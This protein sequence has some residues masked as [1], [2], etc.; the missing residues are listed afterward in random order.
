MSA[1]IKGSAITFA[2]YVYQSLQGVDL[3]CDWL[4]A[5]TCYVRVRFECDDE[6]VVP[7]GLDDVV[8]ERQDGL[9]DV[10]Q[11]KFTPSPE[12]YALDWDWLTSKPG[13][14]G[15]TSRSLL[16]KW[17]DA[18]A[19]IDPAKLGEVSLITNRVPDLS[20][21]TCL[22]GGAFIDYKKASADDQVNVEAELGGEAN[23][24]RFFKL[25]QVR[26]SNKGYLSLD[27][28]VTD[29]LRKHSTAEGIETL[30]NR[31]VQ[32]AVQKKHPAPEGWIT[33]DILRATLR[34]V[35]P[36]P[37]PEDFVIPAGY[38]VPDSECHARFV[39]AVRSVPAQPLVLTG[40]PG[41]G[42]S[43]YLSQLCETLSKRD[44]PYVRHH[45]YLSA[46]D[47]TLDRYTSH[48]VEASL[49]SQIKR[50]H[51]DVSAPDRE[52][53][54][55][56]AACAAYY[57]A[58]GKPFVV[59]IDG[60]DHVW[61]SQGH[62][63][64]PLDQLFEQLLPSA[65]NLV[66]VVGTQPVDDAQLPTRLLVAAPRAS[67]HELP[68]MSADAVLHYLRRQVRQGRLALRVGTPHDESEL[69]EAA[70]ELRSR[71]GG[72]PLHVIYATEELVRTGQ[73][74]SK[75]SVE[76]LSGDLSHGVAAYYASLWHLLSASQRDVLRLI[77]GFTFFWPKTAF[78]QLATLAGTA[79]PEV[80]A[81][82]H[83]LHA[84][85]AGLKPFHESLVV[86]V[87]QTDGFS[88][89]LNELIGYVETWLE[90]AAPQALCVN[91]LWA[92]KARRGHPDNL[93]AGLQR[94]WVLA[95]LQEGYPTTLMESLLANAEEHGVR[96]VRYADAYRLRH[97]KH[98]LL[99]SLSYR[100]MG[101]DAARLQ[102]C[103]WTLTLEDGVIDEA[104]ASRHERAVVDVAALGLALQA[105]GRSSEAEICGRDA[106]RRVRGESR[107]SVRNDGRAKNLYLAKSLTTLGTLDA[108]AAKTARW[109]D[110][111]R[112][113]MGR[114][115]LE[116]Y[117]DRDELRRTVD[118]A[119]ALSRPEIKALACDSS[120]RIAAKAG[121]DL[122]AWAEFSSLS[123]GVLIGCLGALAGKKGATLWIRPLDLKW[124]EGSYEDRRDALSDL[125]HDWFFGAAYAKLTAEGAATQTN[126]PVFLHQEKVSENLDHLGL[127]GWRVAK[128]WLTGTPVKFSHI[129]EAFHNSRPFT[130]YSNFDHSQGA[131]DFRRTLHGIAVDVQLLSTRFGAAADV[132]AADLHHAMDQTWFDA[133]EFR[134][135]YVSSLSK[136]LS[137]EAAE[138]FVRQQ[139]ATF[140]ATVEEETGIRMM[141]M[142]EL[143]EM[144]LRHDL[145]DL[146]AELCRQT[147]ELALGY[148]QRKDPAL[149]DVM[150]ALEYLVPAAPDDARRLL[151][152]IAPQV[153]NVLAFTDGKGT[154]HVPHQADRLL[155]MLNREALVAK[156]REHTEA[157]EWYHAENSLE[158]YVT[159]VPG[160]STMVRAILRTGLHAGA[161]DALKEV[162]D[163]GTSLA[164]ELL[165][166]AVRHNGADIGRISE[167]RGGSTKTE[168]K[169]FPSDVKSYGVDEIDRLIEDLR[170]HYGIR[171]DILREWF[172]HWVGQGQGS[173]LIQELEPRLLSDAVRGHDLSE[174]LEPA[175]DVKLKLAGRPAAFPYIVQAQIF[176]GGWLGPMMEETEESQARLRLVVRHYKRRCDEFFAKSSVSWLDLPRRK[177]VVPSDIM[178]F[179][180]V[181]QGRTAEAV[182]FAEAMVQGVQDDTRTLRLSAPMWAGKLAVEPTQP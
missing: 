178:V 129:Y 118:I 136:V 132:D 97:L 93:V 4:D 173:R 115:L 181:L 124:H 96:L 79:L 33:L 94:D 37:L 163:G 131:R 74:L 14:V 172:A 68:A 3:L 85:P 171:G 77:C 41:R 155:A 98:R 139:K 111:R 66:I 20:M 62:D 107:F 75:W 169:P 101:E 57:K 28:H 39:E 143:C 102:A 89:R 46:T 55:A 69:Q 157:G 25:L 18:L 99:N 1:D 58:R 126:A 19:G 142:L 90:T 52:L 125:A 121:A 105:R 60:L 86:F 2:G 147:W 7:Q 65:D 165:G 61:R 51:S 8:A 164:T 103:T 43:T 50:F 12:K 179:F 80:A 137:D 72:H 9:F 67:W 160:D 36:E 11:V 175:F 70:A 64:R 144:A 26:H 48:A 81:V 161:V 32:W 95:R 47:R 117:G 38:R 176:R 123:N 182:Q 134:T 110:E 71:T 87:K 91:W 145:T 78:D 16:R 88:D 106:L 156:Y 84:S 34:I 5:P 159:T 59:I 63:K 40:P 17:S 114:R 153:H 170:G 130:Y 122:T 22:A 83:L 35:A 167:D 113:E 44:V 128:L 180:L 112:E 154:R 82:E 92:V 53:A 27:H 116:A 146:A 24:L 133:N 158:A 168:W 119:L 45:Y 162:A 13:K 15:G 141:A 29:R 104:F 138:A 23:A 10:K 30:K 49:H 166:E 148:A 31:A 54:P 135:Q 108:T 100:L 76:K 42:K 120:V 21:E 150:D 56:L 174:L 140:E 152:E 177:L 73:A 149:S 6:G 151:A 127:I 109:M